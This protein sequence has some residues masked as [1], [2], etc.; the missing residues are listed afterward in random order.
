[1]TKIRIATAIEHNNIARP[2]NLLPISTPLPFE[3]NLFVYRMDPDAA[4]DGSISK[5]Y[6]SSAKDTNVPT[7]YQFTRNSLKIAKLLAH[8]LFTLQYERKNREGIR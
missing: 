4:G 6:V 8:C 1:M 5:M 3:S 2:T 7:V